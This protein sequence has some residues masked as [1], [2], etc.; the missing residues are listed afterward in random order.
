MGELTSKQVNDLDELMTA[1]GTGEVELAI[2]I[3]QTIFELW[4]KDNQIIVET[5]Y[6]FDRK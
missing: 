3:V 4:E 5:A 1:L 2:N 6:R